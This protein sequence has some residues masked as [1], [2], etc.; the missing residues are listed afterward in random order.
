MTRISPS[1]ARLSH[2]RALHPAQWRDEIRAALVS[3]GSTKPAAE[4][5]GI[6]QSTLVRWLASDA[7][8]ARGLALRKAGRPKQC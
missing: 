3:T 8:I 2:L 7:T 6:A 1:A 5:L 4:A